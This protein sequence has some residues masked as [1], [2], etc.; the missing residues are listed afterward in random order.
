LFQACEERDIQLIS[1]AKTNRQ[2]LFSKLLQRDMQ[3]SGVQEITD[4][5]L[6]DELTGRSKGYSTPV[7]LGTYSFG[8]GSSA[9]VSE[10]EGVKEEP[11]IVSFFVRLDDLDDALRID[12]PTCC[13]GRSE[14]IGDL[15]YRILKNEH[16]AAVP[17]VD[18]LQSDYGGVQVYNALAYVTDLEVRL[19]KQKMYEIYLPMVSEVLGEELR[20]DRSERRFID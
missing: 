8:E 12:V 15:P 10:K 13:I 16:E 14:R 2:A 18:M 3:R 5:A 9:V 4:S 6:F 20:I 17:I 1:I 11:A 7:I 19:T